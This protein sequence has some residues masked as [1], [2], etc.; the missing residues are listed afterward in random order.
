MIVATINPHHTGDDDMTTTIGTDYGTFTI[1]DSR[2]VG[3]GC[4]A[5]L[6][7]DD[8]AAVMWDAQGGPEGDDYCRRLH[9]DVRAICGDRGVAVLDI[10]HPDYTAAQIAL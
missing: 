3:G 6:A 9:R 1:R 8:A 10:E 4:S 2:D 5:T 7:L